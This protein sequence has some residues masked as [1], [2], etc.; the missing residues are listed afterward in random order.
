[1][2]DEWPGV[3][4]DC[5]RDDEAEAEGGGIIIPELRTIQ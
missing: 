2:C 1:V 5:S 3:S 4:C